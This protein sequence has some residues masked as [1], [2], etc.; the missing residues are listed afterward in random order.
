MSDLIRTD[1]RAG[2][3]LRPVKIIP[4]FIPPAEG[5][6]LIEVGATRVI[7]TATV[8]D[9]V[10]GFQKG[11][12]KGWIT[13]EYSMLPRA[14]L[15][16]TLRDASRG[17]VSGRSQEIQRL[18]G[19]SLRAIARLDALGERTITLDCDVIQADGGTRTA[20]ITGAYVALGLACQR[21]VDMRILRSLPLIDSVA[22]TSVGLIEAAPVL[23]LTYEEDARAQV[24]MN[25][26]ITGSGRLVEV[27]ATAETAP[28]SQEE[29]DQMLALARGGIRQLIE[30]QQEILQFNFAQ[31]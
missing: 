25:V 28:F 31:P 9:T 14:T 1:K 20:A 13:A 22:A 10:P 16:R 8:E 30:K 24:D 17:R 27:Q 15:R 6:V 21:L 11:T 19:R 5:S 18:I 2:D 3:E 23:D 12:G 29:L 26:V 7:C 4:E